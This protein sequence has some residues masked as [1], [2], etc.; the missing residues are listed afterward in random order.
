VA[1]GT[2]K[3]NL[4]IAKLMDKLPLK[5]ASDRI[6]GDTAYSG[7]H[8]RLITAWPNPQNPKRGVLIYTAQ[9]ADDIVGINSVFHGPTDYVIAKS[10]E[11]LKAADYKK[12]N[13]R[14]SLK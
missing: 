12:Q 6:E 9:Q 14:W 2:V 5:I 10:T 13:G 1:Y 7:V 11:I 4:W 8:L 3:G